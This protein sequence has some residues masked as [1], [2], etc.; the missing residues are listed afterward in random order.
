MFNVFKAEIINVIPLTDMEKLFEVRIV[1][2]AERERFTFLPGQFV[3]VRCGED[4]VLRRPLSLHRVTPDDSPREIALLYSVQGEGTKWLSLRQRGEKIDLLGPLGNSFTIPPKSR[5]LL[6]VAG[7][8]GV[9]P[10]VFLAQ[11][12]LSRGHSVTLCLGAPAAAQLYP[13]SLLPP[14]VKLVTATDD[15]SAGKKGTVVDLLEEYLEKADAL[16]ACGPVPMYESLLRRI[17]HK[18][19]GIPV[20]VSLEVRMGCGVGACYSCT[21]RTKQGLKQVCKDG[22]VFSLEEVLWDEVRF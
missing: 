18:A 4:A 9:A 21:I 19:S 8:I 20:Q 16:Y 11:R 10:L 2:D 15:G 17:G 6:L 12:A 22:P 1:D 14:G 3:M 5:R 13:A 7:G